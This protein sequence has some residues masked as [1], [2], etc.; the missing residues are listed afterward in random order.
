MGNLMQLGEGE[1]APAGTAAHG[2]LH[3]LSNLDFAKLT[4]ME[5]EYW[6]AVLLLLVGSSTGGSRIAAGR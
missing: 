1:E 4:N 2:V 5:H 3:L 6:W